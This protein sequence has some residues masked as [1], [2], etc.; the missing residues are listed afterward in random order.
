MLPGSLAM[1]P[2]EDELGLFNI[3]PDDY[4]QK[5]GQDLF[6]QYKLYVEMA[7]KVSERRS[8]ANAFFLTA[9]TILIFIYG[10]IFGKDLL[11][12][13]ISAWLFLFALSGLAFSITWFY[14]VQSYR[15]LNSAKLKVLHEIEKNLPLALCKAEGRASGEGRDPDA[16]DLSQL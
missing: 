3:K 9:N 1:K 6:E 5:Y 10:A 16:I 7:D 14:I 8:T 13:S 12:D 2:D 15:R 11:S 4:G